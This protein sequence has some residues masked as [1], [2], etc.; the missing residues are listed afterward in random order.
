YM[1]LLPFLIHTDSPEKVCVQL[2]HL[3]ESVTLSAALEYQGEN[4]S[5]IDDVVSEKDVFTCIPFSLPKSNSQSP[6]TFLTVTVKGATLEFRSRKSVLVQ[7]SE[8]LVFVQTD[9]PIY[10]PG[11]TVLFR[12]VSLDKDFR[13]LNEVDPKKNRLYQWTKAELK[14]GL[15]QLFFNL[16]SEPMQGTYA[17][18]A[19]KASGKTIHHPFS[20]EEY[21]LPKFEVTVKMPKVITIL[22]EKLQ[23]TVCG[24]YTFGKPVPGLVSFRVCRNFEHAATTCYGEEAKA[25]CE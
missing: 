15:I 3:N 6:V 19:Q 4:R 2:T 17:V 22:D 13:P 16:S 9:K 12:I 10:K 1:V 23:V 24:L 25:V 11:Q 20:V 7:N 18:V 14:G 8:S 5:L 21:V